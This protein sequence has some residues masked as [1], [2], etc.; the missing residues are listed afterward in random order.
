M[1]NLWPTAHMWPSPA[2]PAAASHPVPSWQWLCLTEWPS[3]ATAWHAPI[4]Q[5]QLNTG[6]LLALSGLKPGHGEGSVVLTQVMAN[7]CMHFGT[8]V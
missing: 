5:H 8:L 7:N 4:T 1:P 2:Y 3:V 6:V